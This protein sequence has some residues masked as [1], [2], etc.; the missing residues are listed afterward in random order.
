VTLDLIGLIAIVLGGVLGYAL[1]RFLLL[2]RR[3]RIAP[4]P[5]I[6]AVALLSLVTLRLLGALGYEETWRLFAFPFVVG[7]GAGLTFGQAR[8]PRGAWWEV[9]KQ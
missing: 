4:F 2:E 8:L 3:V 6:A 5:V 1:G 7:W 9:W